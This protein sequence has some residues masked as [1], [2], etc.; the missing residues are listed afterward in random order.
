[1]QF[2]CCAPTLFIIPSKG[3]WGLCPHVYQW[4]LTFALELA[5]LPSP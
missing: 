1:M 4:P 3:V 5:L 2:H